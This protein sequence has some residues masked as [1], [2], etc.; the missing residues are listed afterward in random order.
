MRLKNINKANREEIPKVGIWLRLE[1]H[2]HESYSTK[3]DKKNRVKE[4]Q[5][6][7]ENVLMKQCTYEENW[8]LTHDAV[9]FTNQLKF[10][11]VNINGQGAAV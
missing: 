10:F 9:F 5:G 2:A 6:K 7:C 1:K 4:S 8:E 11:I 3:H